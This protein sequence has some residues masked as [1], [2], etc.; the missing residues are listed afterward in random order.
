M[1]PIVCVCIV[2]I[3]IVCAPG[4]AQEPAA[5][6][7]PAAQP[8]KAAQDNPP[9]AD[10]GKTKQLVQEIL[11]ARLAHELVLND[12]QT[13][14][15]LKRFTEYRAQLDM[16]K[17]ERLELIR[18]LRTSVSAKE[19]DTAI[20]T[21]LKALAAHDVKVAEYKKNLY[22]GASEGLSMPQRAKLY[23]FLSDFE[24]DMRK[25]IQK[26]REQSGQRANRWNGP[27]DAPLPQGQA[28]RTIRN[29][30]VKPPQE[31]ETPAPAPAIPA[32][33]KGQ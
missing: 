4:W 21:K 9:N 23:I 17:K 5:P 7:K 27:A 15:M 32:P 22:D 33:P 29:R 20:E 10:G 3:G 30:V 8:A 2:A 26:A 13:V 18:A 24:S 14:I 28:P 19:A 31:P 16:F 25:L 12:E 11:M 1:K 6:Q